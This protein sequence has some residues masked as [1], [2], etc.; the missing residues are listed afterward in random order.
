MQ[1]QSDDQMNCFIRGEILPNSNS[2]K[3]LGTIITSNGSLVME[4][5]ERIKKAEHAMGML[6]AVWSSNL[7]SVHSKIKIYI[8]LVRSIL[9]YGHQS[10][11]ITV[12]RYEK[13]LDL[14]N[15]IVEK[16]SGDQIATSYNK[17]CSK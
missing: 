13:L 12:L 5:K 15:K 14:E 6:K 4:F 11:Y 9:T 16:N 10:W 2:F 3:Y 17:C 7:I 1:I 8:S